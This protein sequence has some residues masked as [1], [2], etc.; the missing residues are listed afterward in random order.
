VN[1]L[2]SE[3]EVLITGITQLGTIS[4]HQKR[5]VATPLQYNNLEGK[6]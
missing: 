5:G 3:T 4:L 2:L 1:C 6:N